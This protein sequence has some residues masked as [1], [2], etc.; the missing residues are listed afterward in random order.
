MLAETWYSADEAVAAGLADEI[1]G[2]TTADPDTDPAEIVENA[3]DLS[4]FKYAGR[5]DAPAPQDQ[6]TEPAPAEPTAAQRFA[7]RRAAGDRQARHD[8]RASARV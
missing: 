6:I 3:F 2:A 8:R 5:T 1:E 7:A 4:I